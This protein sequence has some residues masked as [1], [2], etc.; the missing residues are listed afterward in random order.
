MRVRITGYFHESYWYKDKVGQ[1]FEVQEYL[2]DMH[3]VIPWEYPARYIMV[4]D[5]VVI[6][7]DRDK[8]LIEIGINE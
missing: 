7:E 1:T 6:D 3:R 8:K 4:C 5:C 2:P